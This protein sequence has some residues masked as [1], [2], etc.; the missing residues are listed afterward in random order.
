M[1]FEMENSN[2]YECEGPFAE[3]DCI[4]F[5]FGFKALFTK[6]KRLICCEQDAADKRNWKKCYVRKER[7]LSYWKTDI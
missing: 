2:I 7:F 3:H 4:K 5:I 6:N 1:T